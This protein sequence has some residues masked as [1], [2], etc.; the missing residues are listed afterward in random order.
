MSTYHIYSLASHHALSPEVESGGFTES[1]QIF[2]PCFEAR[3]GELPFLMPEP[4]E[5]P[6]LHPCKYVYTYVGTQHVL[7]LMV[8]YKDCTHT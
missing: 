8:G 3:I 1:R 5:K 7:R 2:R 6:S 4:V